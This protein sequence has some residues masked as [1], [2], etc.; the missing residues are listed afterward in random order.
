M[1]SSGFRRRI[2][3]LVGMIALLSILGVFAVVY[4]LRVASQTEPTPRPSPT[5]APYI[6]LEPTQAV[7]EETVYITVRGYLWPTDGR[8]VNLYWDDKVHFLEGPV[9]IDAG[10]FEVDVEVTA[11]WATPGTH[12]VIAAID[13]TFSTSA[14]IN[15]V[16]PTPTNTPTASLTPSPTVATNTPSPTSTPSPTGTLEPT[17][18]TQ[19][20]A[21]LRPVTPVVTGA[22]VRPPVYP[23]S[24][25]YYYPTTA[26][27]RYPLPTNTS[28]PRPT[29]VPPTSTPTPTDTPTLTPSPT[30]TD[31]PT[32][33][34]SPTPTDTPT[35]TPSPTP[36]D[37]PT[38]TPTPTRTPMPGAPGVSEP[39]TDAGLP[40]AGGSWESVF[41]QGFV[42]A[43]LLVVLLTAF[44]IVVLVILLV[45]WR[46][47]RMRRAEGHI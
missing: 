36:T 26:V 37:T 29:S 17:L 42:A 2:I 20:T 1:N 21:T 14:D 6:E 23:T 32:I 5:L 39:S 16:V 45:V 25:P 34:P 11:Q 35:I 41:L 30:P 22:P 4:P 8:T 44:I 43:V 33:T 46:I 15:L 9:A 13:S 38:L 28:R 24:P 3:N 40:A 10:G 18:T 31:T 7:G 27:T 12:Q 47:L 19:P